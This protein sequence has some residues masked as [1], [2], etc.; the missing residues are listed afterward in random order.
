[1]TRIVILDGHTLNPGDLSWNGFESLGPCAVHPRTAPADVVARSEGAD[2]LLTNKTP[3][4]AETIGRLP[5]L[6][7]IGVLAT[8]YNVVDTAA[9]RSR[10]VPVTNVPAYGTRSVAQHAWALLLELTQGISGHA[11]SVREGRWSANPDWCYWDRPL[12]ELHGLTL[13]IV[14]AGRIG[15]E[16]GRIA[17]AFGMVV[18][19]ATRQG[20]PAELE[21][22]LRASD[23]VSL[24]C[25]LTPETRELINARTIA[26]MKPT[27][28]L[29][30]TSR[31]PLVN[32]TDLAQA[33]NAGRI[34]GAAMD[35]LSTEP[36]A[37]DNP[38]I[39][40]R[41]CLIT[42]HHAWATTAARRRL[43][44]TALDNLKAFLAGKPVNVVN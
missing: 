12:V 3:L 10:G 1:M 28:F 26:L 15:R 33:L 21:S 20:G 42:P 39:T 19:Q 38:L 11:R 5:A 34:A 18:R 14:G 44:A 37:R 36:P 16:V 13:G 24:H 25:P 40:A 31:G 6:R 22:V 7:Y 17:E 27:A 35:V 29:L 41:N 8:G 43:L 30:N 23:V 2:I 32:E 9:A 4:S